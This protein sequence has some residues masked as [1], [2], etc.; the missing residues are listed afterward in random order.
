MLQHSKSLVLNSQA[1]KKLMKKL[2]GRE[3]KCHQVNIYIEKYI[4][5]KINK[6]KNTYIEKQQNQDNKQ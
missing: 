5:K 2:F 1:N 3:S 4:A 6:M